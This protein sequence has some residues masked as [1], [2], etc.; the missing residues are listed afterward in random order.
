MT[1]G[2]IGR[3]ANDLAARAASDPASMVV[4][5]YGD[6]TLADLM[7]SI[8]AHLGVP[9]CDRPA[10]ELPDSDRYVVV[11]I[12]GLGWQ[13]VRRAIQ[14]VPYLAGL[15]GDA[16][17]ITSA[18]PSTTVTSLACLGTGLPPGQHGLVGYTSR[19]PE[20]G[21]LLNALT[22]DSDVV[23]RSYQPQPTF[24]ERAAA[25]GVAVSS[26]A[27][28]RFKVTGLT[29]AALR[30][31]DFV[32]FEHEKH[33]D[34]RIELTVAASK[35]GRRSLVYAYERELDHCGHVEGSAS[36]T[37]LEHLI[38]IDA[39]CER[40]RDELPD[41]V[42]MVITGDHGMID[43]PP[44][45]RLVV[46]DE[47]ELVAGM[48]ALAG[49]GRFRQVYVDH[50]NPQAVAARWRDRLGDTA[51]VL[52]RDEAIDAGWFGPVAGWVRDRYGHVLVAM[53]D[54]YALM[55]RQFPRELSLVGMHGSLTPAE[56]MVPLFTD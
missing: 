39:M 21:E 6:S 49:E 47:P 55:T 31:A 38:R 17:P 10:I 52:T 48:S 22:W 24:F 12:D 51:W 30:G 11:L 7:P 8:G 34:T 23:A 14:H 1:P 5:R 35:R 25:D 37:W 40:L 13:L 2:S 44:G 42:R 9:G 54:D 32:S 26:V 41:D 18:V 45:H 19:V 46:E 4:P 56:I 33:E 16:E 15:L 27:L 28:E 43:V 50:D 20:T 53:R 36:S 29:E 3:A